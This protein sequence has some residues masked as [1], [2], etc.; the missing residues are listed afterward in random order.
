MVPKKPSWLVAGVAGI[1]LSLGIFASSIMPAGM[2]VS[3]QNWINKDND[4]PLVAVVDTDS[5]L[6]QWVSKQAGSKINDNFAVVPG[7]Y[8]GNDYSPTEKTTDIT[9][10]DNPLV[11]ALNT[12]PVVIKERIVEN[13]SAKI[14]VEDMDNS[15]RDLKQVASASGA[16]FNIQVANRI[17]TASAAN[18]VQVIALEVPKDNLDNLLNDLAA[19]GA[20]VPAKDT[21]NY[22]QA[23]A[24]TEQALKELEQDIAKLQS[25]SSL[26][27]E[28]KSAASKKLQ[29]KQIDLLA[30]KTTH[31]QGI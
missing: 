17:L 30:E 12:D 27:A 29:N 2:M 23:Y 6:K 10:T 15:L 9:K 1:A 22:T 7:P 4:K 18:D 3:L 8:V 19:M 21:S 5:I 25:Q 20:G 11:A 24:E 14:K 28:Q 31:R 13:Y 26:S 16:R